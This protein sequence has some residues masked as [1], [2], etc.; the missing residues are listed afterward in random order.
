MSWQHQNSE[1]HA[2]SPSEV[3]MVTFEERICFVRGNGLGMVT[4]C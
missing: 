1:W 2:A 3:T 4:E